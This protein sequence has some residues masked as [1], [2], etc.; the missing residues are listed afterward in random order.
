MTPSA[1]TRLILALPECQQASH[2]GT[3]DFRARGKIFA[4]R[5]TF[6][7]LNLNL[8]REQQE[9]LVATEPAIFAALSNTWGEKCGTSARIENLD[10]ATARSVLRVAWRNVATKSLRAAE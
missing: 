3:T 1:L 10:A 5:P 6:A 8:T 9:M 4:T 2:F 7:A